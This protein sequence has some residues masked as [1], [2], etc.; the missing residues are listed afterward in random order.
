MEKITRS[1]VSNIYLED[2]ANNRRVEVW[3][4]D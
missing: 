4:T 3:L 1:V 2:R